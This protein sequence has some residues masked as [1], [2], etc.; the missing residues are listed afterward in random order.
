[1]QRE[2]EREREK[3]YKFKNALAL[4]SSSSSSGPCLGPE[5]GT[6]SKGCVHCRREPRPCARVWILGFGFGFGFGCG[7]RFGH[8]P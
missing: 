7:R 8:G 4:S 2:R 1:M 3:W 6:C 5:V